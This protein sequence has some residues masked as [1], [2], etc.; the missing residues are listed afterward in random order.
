MPKPYSTDLRE[1]ILHAYEQG[2]TSPSKL[3][4]LFQVSRDTIRRYLVRFQTMGTIEPEPHGGGRTAL[5]G[6]ED[7][8]RLAEIVGENPDDTVAQMSEK[9][10]KR[11]G[12]SI[13][14]SSMQRALA[15]FGLSSKKKSLI[16]VEQTRPDVIA[17]RK[18]YWDDVAPVPPEKIVFLDETGSNRGMT[19]RTAWAP[20]G[21]R[22]VDLVPGNKGKNVTLIGAV[23]VNG[24]VAMRT[25]EAALNKESFT[26]YIR[27]ALVPSLEPGD[28]VVMD[29]LQVHYDVRATEA[30]E[31][32][33]AFV[34][35]LPPYS[36]DM[37]P[38]ELVWNALKR[39]AEK[40]AFDSPE[41]IRRS[42]K[43]AWRQ[44]EKVDFRGMFRICGYAT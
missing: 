41:Q 8:A 30:I 33:G 5:I 43:S 13:S 7:V 29:N 37:N 20:V 11:F 15:R 35:F 31:K 42:L 38:I 18:K 6:L 44:L 16:S 2:E 34:Y 25:M 23:R 40:L 26:S 36:P 39:R 12:T 10:A 28:V 9:Y 4:A 27:S 24:P 22:A 3:A 1:R 19:K 14:K 32:A 21:C 17:R